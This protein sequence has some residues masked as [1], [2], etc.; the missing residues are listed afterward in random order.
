[1]TRRGPG[2]SDRGTVRTLK[3]H[4]CEPASSLSPSPRPDP[5]LPAPP[6]R[7]RCGA[8]PRRCR[9]LAGGGAGG[10]APGLWQ[11]AQTLAGLKPKHGRGW[12]SLRR[13]FAI[14]FM[15]QPLNVLCELGGWKNAHTFLKCYRRDSGRLWKAAGG[16]APE[17]PIGGSQSTGIRSPALTKFNYH[18]WIQDR[19][20][21]Q[22]RAA[23]LRAAG[24]T[25]ARARARS[26]TC[27]SARSE[28]PT[29][30]SPGQLPY[31]AARW[32]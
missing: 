13:K 23:T 22:H 18:N 17:I 10:P 15:G 21:P 1:M 24:P 27:Q 29:R 6:N 25:R 11:R 8:K 31:G 12:H 30:Q 16:C 5:R 14:D 7:A 26:R 2:C 19:W 32:E 4:D 3:R 28:T 20:H 9:R